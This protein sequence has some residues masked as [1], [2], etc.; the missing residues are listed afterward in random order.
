MLQALRGK[1]TMTITPISTIIL[2]SKNITRTESA[3]EF[4]LV[5]EEELLSVSKTVMGIMRSPKY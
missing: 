5:H 3:K 4:A 2:V 1:K